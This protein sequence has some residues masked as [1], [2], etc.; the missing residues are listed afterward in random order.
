MIGIGSFTPRVSDMH[1]LASLASVTDRLQVRASVP[2][3]RRVP[4][5][6]PA[7]H[8][9]GSGAAAGAP[10]KGTAA[11]RRDPRQEARR[12]AVHGPAECPS[13]TL[14]RVKRLRDR[15]AMTEIRETANRMTFGKVG[16]RVAGAC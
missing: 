10:G 2:H 8:R 1:R 13:P 9:E 12:Q 3:C 7:Q 16:V 14:H 4:R 6:H 11:S 5:L 15:T